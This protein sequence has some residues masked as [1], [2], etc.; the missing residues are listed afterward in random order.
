M[1]NRG[2]PRKGPSNISIGLVVVAL[3][4]VTGLGAGLYFKSDQLHVSTNSETLCP[5]DRPVAEITVVL[6][7]VSDEFSE[8]QL[9]EVQNRLM[10]LRNGLPHLGLIEVY[11]V[12]SS[13]Q[14]VT[15]PLIHLC[16]PGTGE[17]LNRLY[18]NPGLA[19]KHWDAFAARLETQVT[20]LLAAPDSATSPIYE[21]I[22]STA[23][24]TFGRPEYDGVPK[25]LVVVSDLMQNVPEKQSHY[26]EPPRFD[27]F[28]QSP[29]FSQVRADLDSVHVDLYYLRRS[30]LAAQ[31]TDHIRFWEE[32]L[33]AQ[34]AT[35]DSVESIY[36][37][38]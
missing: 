20:H 15:T 1:T 17:D 6:L 30:G 16:N 34:G 9:I 23:L 35:V 26:R 24:R 12:D 14:R 33:S 10:R 28:R 36:G 13:T 4:A 8:P 37:D 22:Q 19:K 29:Y 27:T 32:Y 11:A 2:V 7:D 21:A 38:K 25:H 3:L 18:Q 5:T 31:G